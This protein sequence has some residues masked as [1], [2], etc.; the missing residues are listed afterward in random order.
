MGILLV[1]GSGLVLGMYITTQIQ[2]RINNRI[3][4]K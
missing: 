3:K 2:K 4:K 1:F